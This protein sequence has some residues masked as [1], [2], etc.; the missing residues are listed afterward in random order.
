MKQLLSY[1]SKLIVFFTK[2]FDFVG[3]NVMF[4]VCCLPVITIPAAWSALLTIK[5]QQQSQPDLAIYTTFW[6]HIKEKW[7][8]SLKVSLVTLTILGLM[9]ILPSRFG[10]IYLLPFQVVGSIVTLVLLSY[11]F[12]LTGLYEMNVKTLLRNCGFLFMTFPVQTSLLI[13]INTVVIFLS[14]TSYAGILISVYVYLFG[15]FVG[16]AILN[17]WVLRHIFK[18]LTSD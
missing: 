10:L 16:L 12:I 3:L 18:Q 2:L 4:M 5:Y 9:V 15:G 6:K 11:Q 7:L 17:A 8:V 13:I 14:V 1:D